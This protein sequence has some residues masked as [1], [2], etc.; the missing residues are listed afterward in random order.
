M[1]FLYL[2]NQCTVSQLIS[3]IAASYF[4]Q[5]LR[6]FLDASFSLG[7]P[8]TSQNLSIFTISFLLV[9]DSCLVSPIFKA[10]CF[11]CSQEYLCAL[12][13]H[14]NYLLCVRY[15]NT[16]FFTISISIFTSWCPLPSYTQIF[17]NIV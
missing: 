5:L 15:L 6:N 2:L 11:I 9:S 10:P 8:Q 1:I 12:L 17:L 13:H 4:N 3:F 7:G 14:K 16:P